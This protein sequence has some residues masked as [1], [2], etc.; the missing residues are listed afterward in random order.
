MK[1]KYAGPKNNIEAV[2]MRLAHLEN[3]LTNISKE[4]DPKCVICIG[5]GVVRSK[6][7]TQ[8]GKMRFYRPCRCTKI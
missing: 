4:P 5:I 6:P 2:Q 7:Y 1:R 8:E 3:K